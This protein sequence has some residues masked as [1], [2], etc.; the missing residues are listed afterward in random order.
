M[1]GDYEFTKH[2]EDMELLEKMSHVAAGAHAPF[3]TAS[4]PDLMSMDSF[5]DIGQVRDIAKLF[6]NTEYAKWKSFRESED[7]RYVG[8][9]LPH[10]LMRLPYGRDTKTSGGF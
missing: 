10:I 1:V 7:S 3:L 8:L 5:S 2:P 6:D 4:A 9:C